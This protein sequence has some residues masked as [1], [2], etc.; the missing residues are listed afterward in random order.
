MLLK[1][2]PM[3]HRV[4]ILKRKHSHIYAHSKALC[5][6][7]LATLDLLM[8]L[9]NTGC[10][11]LCCNQVC[12]KLF[13]RRCVIS[14]HLPWG[15]KK[16]N[17]IHRLTMWHQYSIWQTQKWL[18]CWVSNLENLFSKPA[19][20]KSPLT[21]PHSSLSWHEECVPQRLLRDPSDIWG[22]NA[23]YQLL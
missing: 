17:P 16:R 23:K 4:L 9:K 2:H 20:L 13:A 10:P 8:R 6:H 21:K 5:I 18:E 22:I 19:L 11:G 15:T 14:M 1:Q 7:A 3:R 12:R